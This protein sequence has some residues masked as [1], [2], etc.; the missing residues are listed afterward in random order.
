MYCI[1]ITIL[2]IFIGKH[3]VSALFYSNDLPLLFENCVNQISP[4]LIIIYNETIFPNEIVQLIHESYDFLVITMGN[5]NSFTLLA[6]THD[7]YHLHYQILLF[8]WDQNPFDFCYVANRIQMSFSSISFH[9]VLIFY[10]AYEG[11]EELKATMNTYS[12]RPGRTI[13]HFGIFCPLNVV[14]QQNSLNSSDMLKDFTCHP[15]YC[16][17]HEQNYVKDNSMSNQMLQHQ[18]LSLATESTQLKVA[19]FPDLTK[20]IPVIKNNNLINY[21][22]S[23]AYTVNVIAEYLNMNIVWIPQSDNTTFGY[24][25][26]N[27]TITGTSGDVAYGRA[28]IAANSRYMKINWPEVQYTYPHDTDSLCF[29]VPKSKRVPQ[30]KNI[31]LPFSNSLW[32]ALLCTIFLSSITWYW[33]RKLYY[34]NLVGITIIAAFLEIYGSFL[35]GMFNL[36]P[37]LTIERL[38]IIVWVMFGIIITSSFQG[39]LTSFLSVP[40]YLKDINNLHELDMS[41]FKLIVYEGIDSIISLNPD[42]YIMKRLW[43]KFKYLSDFTMVPDMMIKTQNTGCMFNEYSARYFHRMKKYTK[44]GYPLLHWVKENILTSYS[45]YEVP[46]NSRYLHKFNVVITRLVES[47]I[48]RKWDNDVLYQ[49]MLQGNITNEVSPKTAR[50]QSLSLYHMQTAFY[51]LSIGLFGSLLEFAIELLFPS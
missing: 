19:L 5:T 21:E 45:V 8:I 27:G 17:K 10:D 14:L 26:I 36:Q 15:L 2:F 37:N 25:D 20:A 24:R 38:Y 48:R 49:A 41:G 40:K 22:G 12:V 18:N 23:D 46:R 51:I 32:T 1:S 3:S 31:F 28:D 29:V 44:D 13:E 6:L 30:Y 35:V 11:E 42:D 34:K 39:S 9:V 33:I 7:I 50:I 43:N 16:I 47:G 4:A